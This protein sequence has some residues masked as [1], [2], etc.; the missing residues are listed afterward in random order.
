MTRFDLRPIE[1]VSS[2]GIY[3]LGVKY[4]TKDL[5]LIRE[6]RVLEYLR[7]KKVDIVITLVFK[8]RPDIL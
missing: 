6:S 8:L 5:G 7:P 1:S 3:S 4:T 2:L